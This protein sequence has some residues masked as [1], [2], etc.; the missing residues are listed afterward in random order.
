MHVQSVSKKS[1]KLMTFIISYFMS[2]VSTSIREN[3]NIFNIFIQTKKKAEKRTN[4]FPFSTEICVSS[5]CNSNVYFISWYPA[6]FWF[7]NAVAPPYYNPFV[8][9]VCR[10]EN[11]TDFLPY[12]TFDASGVFMCMKYP[13]FRNYMAFVLYLYV[14][15]LLSRRHPIIAG[16]YLSGV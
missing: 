15:H 3:L 7:D 10:S 6:F 4:F 5:F 9:I 16:H 14:N 2:I 13:I 1:R 8:P 12:A 11:L